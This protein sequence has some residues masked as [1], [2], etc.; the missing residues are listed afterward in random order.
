MPS[1]HT[2]HRCLLA[3]CLTLPVGAAVAAP[4]T[5]DFTVNATTGPLAGQSATG[6]FTYDDSI[7]FPDAFFSFS[8]G[9]GLLL[10]LALTWNGIDYDETNASTGGISFFSG[11][12]SGVSFGTDCGPT[13]GCDTVPGS[14]SWQLGTFATGGDFSY[15][16][17]GSTELHFG[18]V[19][20]PQLRS[21]PEPA[22][23]ALALP[24]LLA[25]SLAR[26]KP[27]KQA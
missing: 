20:P 8:F 24:G 26:R 27:D 3:A 4:I 6:Y 17:P 9:P 15:S 16:T 22:S 14:E 7:S 19:T 5:Y 25:L 13:G 12:F 21:V 1:R 2:L 18:T 11:L 23:L 10:D